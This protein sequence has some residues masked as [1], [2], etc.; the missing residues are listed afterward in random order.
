MKG[1]LNNE[2]A[3]GGKQRTPV[4]PVWMTNSIGRVEALGS[5]HVNVTVACLSIYNAGNHL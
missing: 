5:I 1:N 4:N 2:T 3:S